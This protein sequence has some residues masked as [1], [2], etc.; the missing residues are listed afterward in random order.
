MLVRL[1]QLQKAQSPM[2]V[3]LLGMVMLVRPVQPRKAS[4]P[5]LVTLLGMVML[6]RPVQPQKAPFPMLVTGFPSISDGIVIA[7]LADSLQSVM[8]TLLSELTT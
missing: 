4:P 2:L 6:V 8:V 1:V 3:T 7:P 5:M